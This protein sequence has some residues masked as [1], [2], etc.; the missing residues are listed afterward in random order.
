MGVLKNYSPEILQHGSAPSYLL[1]NFTPR[2]S[3]FLR[4]KRAS[5]NEDFFIPLVK[6]CQAD[7]FYYNGISDWNFS[8]SHIK[9]T[10]GKNVFKTKV[11][12]FILQRRIFFNIIVICYTI[13]QN[14]ILPNA[15]YQFNVIMY[16]QDEFI[17]LCMV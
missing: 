12:S 15:Y 10:N 11:K 4:N 9:C 1:E 6:T 17:S 14:I 7:T 2:S 16:T 3:V 5:S 13:R 8:P